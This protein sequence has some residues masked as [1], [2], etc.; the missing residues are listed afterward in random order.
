MSADGTS[1]F[2]TVSHSTLPTIDKQATRRFRDQFRSTTAALRPR[3]AREISMDVQ[4]KI[5]AQRIQ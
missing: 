5:S 2:S 1:K 4:T 3:N